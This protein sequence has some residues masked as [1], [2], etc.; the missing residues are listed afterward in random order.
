M[1]LFDAPAEENLTILEIETG[2]EAKRK[3]GA[4]GLHINDNIIKINDNKNGPVLIQHS[5]SEMSKLA[6]GKE[7]A[8]KIR[9]SQNA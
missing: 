8:K 4:I 7:L 5:M 3:L 6:I 9:V 1:S 2:T